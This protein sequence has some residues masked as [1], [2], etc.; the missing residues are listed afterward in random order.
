[1]FFDDWEQGREL[2]LLVKGSDQTADI[3]L[4]GGVAHATDIT[5]DGK[6][7]QLIKLTNKVGEEDW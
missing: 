4:L 2:R 7:M 3:T 5:E 6:R 1:M